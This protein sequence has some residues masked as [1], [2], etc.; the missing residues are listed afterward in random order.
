MTSEPNKEGSALTLGG[1]DPKY[2]ATPFKY[3]PVTQKLWY[4]ISFHNKLIK[5]KNKVGNKC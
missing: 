4:N 2:A 3:Y 5:L 1:V